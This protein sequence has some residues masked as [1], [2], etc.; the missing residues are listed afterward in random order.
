[1]WSIKVSIT[2]D[3]NLPSSEQVPFVDY[4]LKFKLDSVTTSSIVSIS[5]HKW[6]KII[7]TEISRSS[8]QSGVA[9]SDQIDNILGSA[10]LPVH[11]CEHIHL[12]QSPNHRFCVINHVNLHCARKETSFT[13]GRSVNKSQL[14]RNEWTSLLKLQGNHDS[15]LIIV[16]NKPTEGGGGTC[17][18]NAA[19]ELCFYKFWDFINTYLFGKLCIVNSNNAFNDLLQSLTCQD[20]TSVTVSRESGSRSYLQ[21]SGWS[22]CT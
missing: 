11:P 21:L 4:Y 17:G 20:S 5:L 1:M 15:T 8:S 16:W 10:E 18:L 13:Y 19:L 3:V 14:A 6:K 12:L 22:A 9:S 7:L 2:Y